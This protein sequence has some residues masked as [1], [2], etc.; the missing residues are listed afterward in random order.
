MFFSFKIHFQYYTQDGLPKKHLEEGV[1]AVCDM[2]LGPNSRSK[3]EE[4]EA[5]EE[6][7]YK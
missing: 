7:T 2:S 5:T 1:C 3:F 4:G 6:Q